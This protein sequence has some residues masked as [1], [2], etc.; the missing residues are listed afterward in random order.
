MLPLVKIP[1]TLAQNL[2]PYRA[3][4]C[5]TAGFAQVSCYLTGLL[6]SPNQTLQ[7]IY[8]QWVWPARETVGRRAMPAAVVE[9]AGWDCEALMQRHRQVVVPRIQVEGERS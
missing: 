2:Q 7:G 5:R 9:S 6:L 8:A 4:F 3:V 1:Q